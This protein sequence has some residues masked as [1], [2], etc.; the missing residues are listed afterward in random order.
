MITFSYLLHVRYLIIFNC[1]YYYYDLI[2]IIKYLLQFPDSTWWRRSP[3]V[4]QV[5][6]SA[7]RS[8]SRFVHDQRQAPV[9]KNLLQ[10][11][12]TPSTQL[13]LHAPIGHEI[14]LPRQFR[15]PDLPPGLP[16]EHEIP[17]I[18]LGRPVESDLWFEAEQGAGPAPGGPLSEGHDVRLQGQAPRSRAQLFHP[19][20]VDRQSVQ[21]EGELHNRDDSFVTGIFARV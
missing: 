11:L 10:I 5:R 13:L 17:H 2:A 9:H 1:Y 4:P 19:V 6:K 21:W 20:R 16:A 3:Q 18:R 14:I 15:R 8:Q 12:R 7:V